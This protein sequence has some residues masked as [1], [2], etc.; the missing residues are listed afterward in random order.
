M[1]RDQLG[2]LTSHQVF[3]H[4]GKTNRFKHFRRVNVPRFNFNDIWSLWIRSKDGHHCKKKG[5]R[6]FSF[7]PNQISPQESSH[8]GRAGWAAPGGGPAR[9]DVRRNHRDRAERRKEGKA[10]RG[11]APAR[12][13]WPARPEVPLKAAGLWERPYSPLNGFRK[14]ASVR[15]PLLARQQPGWC[16]FRP[17]P[18][19][20]GFG[21]GLKE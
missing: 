19:N 3:V 1:P 6:A 9:A 16:K 10:A 4:V 11:R 5:Q 8:D 17:R 12:A 20:L 13:H 7:K 21:I 14:G 2:E 15:A 18:L